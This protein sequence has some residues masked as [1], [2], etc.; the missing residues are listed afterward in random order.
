MEDVK[1]RQLEISTVLDKIPL[2]GCGSSEGMWRTVLAIL[3][4]S[5]GFRAAWDRGDSP[6]G[7][8]SAMGDWPPLAV[9]FAA[10]VLNTAGLMEHGTSVGWAWLTQAGKLV[11]EF[12]RKYGCDN[13]KW[14][15][16][17]SGPG[18]EPRELTA[19]QWAGLSRAS[20]DDTVEIP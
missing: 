4:R 15:E 2:C 14:P 19:E 11:L 7:F 16:W 18:E 9:E 8:Y 20:A 10:Q 17:A 12:L 13:D 3:E 6:D 1:L 5:A